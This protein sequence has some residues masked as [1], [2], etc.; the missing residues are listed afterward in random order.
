M[1]DVPTTLEEYRIIYAKSIQD[2]E[3]FWAGKAR[4][5]LHWY[6]DF[7]TIHTGNFSDGD[8][9]WFLEGRLNASYNCIDRH[10]L[11]DRHKIAIIS[12]ADE[13]GNERSITY[14][15]LLRDVSR[16]SYILK[17]MGV[18]KGDVVVIYL[19]NI[20]EALVAILAC[21][22]IGA[23]HSVVF[24]GFSAASLRDRILDAR[25]KFIITTDEARRGG[26]TIATK[27]IVNE[28]LLQCPL[29]SGCLVLRYTGSDVP[30]SPSRD[31]WWHEEAGKWPAYFPPESMSAED[32]LFLLY[33][34][35]STGKPKGLMHTTAGFLLGAAITTK[36]VFDLQE[37]DRYFC[38]GDIGW[39]TGH[40]YLVYGPLL[41]GSTTVIF[42][43]TPSYP[44]FSRFWDI[45]DKHGITHF[46][47]APTAL[48]ILKR[49]GPSHITAPMK[50][51][52]VLGSI[53]EP[54]A[55]EVWKWYYETVGRGR[56][57]IVDVSS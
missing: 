9:A 26:K 6:Q 57:Y 34:S 3:H 12:E 45:I 43:G 40:T 27:V 2:P 8:N 33:T 30:W 50:K 4:E 29:V 41:L 49:A 20:P 23:V 39:I 56:A 22:R 19:P 46:Y 31:L 36:Y 17:D 54:I 44:T 52:R 24:M 21:S 48:R 55:P 37:S 35:G 18:K 7:Q 1:Y 5:L 14:G 13:P 42:E 47:A 38:A 11:R 16:L 28:A 15:E 25:S 32:P 53:G 51:L 10:A